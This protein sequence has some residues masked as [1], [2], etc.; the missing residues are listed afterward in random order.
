MAVR[1]VG[2]VLHLW[3]GLTAADDSGQPLL[4]RRLFEA[5]RRGD[6]EAMD[7]AL[8]AGAD[9]DALIPI[10][11][12]DNPDVSKVTALMQAAL[13]GRVDTIKYLLEQGADVDQEDS[14]GFTPM[15]GCAFRG[16]A[17]A[18]AALLEDVGPNSETALHYHPDGFAP[19]H[20]CCFGE[21]SIDTLRVFLEAG[22]DPALPSIE[23]RAGRG[24]RPGTTCKDVATGHEI[25][26]LLAQYDKGKTDASR[27]RRGGKAGRMGSRR[28]KKV[29]VEQELSVDDILS[30]HPD[31]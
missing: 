15:H 12:Q 25:R 5:A 2:F 18:C 27:K 31:L 21:G 28:K 20:R 7:A 3:V 9:I 11:P 1:C 26:A 6:V 23:D 19:L 8:E 29:T 4:D 17:A 13:D 16:H 24:G 30:A 14:F 22:V 10:G